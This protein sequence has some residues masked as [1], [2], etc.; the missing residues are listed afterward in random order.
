MVIVLAKLGLI[1]TQN[2]AKTVLTSD[3]FIKLY[4]LTTKFLGRVWMWAVKNFLPRRLVAKESSLFSHHIMLG[5]GVNQP[6]YLKG[7]RP[8]L[9]KTSWSAAAVR[10]GLMPPEEKIIGPKTGVDVVEKAFYRVDL[11]VSFWHGSNYTVSGSL[12]NGRFSSTYPS[13][14]IPPG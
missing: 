11:N 7:C 12:V 14:L 2:N 8:P 9:A 1:A 4:Q 6:F 10:R 3:F 13:A 5:G